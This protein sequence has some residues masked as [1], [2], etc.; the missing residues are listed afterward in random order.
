MTENTDAAAGVA[1]LAICK[2]LLLALAGSKLLSVKELNCPDFLG[3]W[4]V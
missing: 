3:G 2:S 1:A 4:L